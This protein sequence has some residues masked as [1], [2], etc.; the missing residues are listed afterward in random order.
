MYLIFNNILA[1]LTD[2]YRVN[3]MLKLLRRMRRFEPRGESTS[4]D[5]I[6][7]GSVKFC[8]NL[9]VFHEKVSY[10]IS[11]LYEKFSSDLIS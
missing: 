3:A 1:Y 10:E 2:G 7:A 8:M 9:F 5:I 6:P 11:V 4:L